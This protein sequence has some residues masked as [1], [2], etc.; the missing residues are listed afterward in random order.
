MLRPDLGRKLDG[1]ARKKLSRL[2][3]DLGPLDLAFIVSDGLAAAAAERHALATLI[4]LHD[5]LIAAGWRLGPVLVVPFAR[6]KLQDEIGAILQARFTLML[7]GERPGLSAPD[8]LGAYFTA[9]PSLE[10]TDADRNCI[11]N[12]RE[13]GLPPQQAALKLAWLLLESKRSGRS[14]I[15]LKDTDDAPAVEINLKTAD[16]WPRETQKAPK[17]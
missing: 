1:E 10:R 17:Q 11:S 9:E 8:S 13:E 5:R 7:L 4:P 15:N 6:V 12:I 2:A 3:H 16:E 14:G